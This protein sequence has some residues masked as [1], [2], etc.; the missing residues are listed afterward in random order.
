MDLN[1]FCLS[2]W[3]LGFLVGFGFS[4]PILGVLGLS[5]HFEILQ[6]ERQFGC[7]GGASN[8]LESIFFCGLLCK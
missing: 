2:L 1:L 7:S 8:S 3:V 5:F 6:N 4:P